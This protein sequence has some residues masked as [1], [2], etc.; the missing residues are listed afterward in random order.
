MNKQ[1]KPFSFA[2]VQKKLQNKVL[3]FSLTMSEYNL[4]GRWLLCGWRGWGLP[5][6]IQ[7]IPKHSTNSE[8]GTV[9]GA[10]ELF[11]SQARDV[12]ETLTTAQLPFILTANKIKLLAQRLG[13]LLVSLSVA[14]ILSV[15]LVYLTAH[16]QI[17][18]P[19][20]CW[21]SEHAPNL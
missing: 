3:L 18:P 20:H 14:A 9:K 2:I 17:C 1:L 13:I 21:T 16:R 6:D 8:L 4:R 10:L 11:I 7:G 5:R 12:T 15:C 19:G